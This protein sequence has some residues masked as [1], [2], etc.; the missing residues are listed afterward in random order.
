ML[1]LQQQI[2]NRTRTACYICNHNSISA[3]VITD[4]EV[5]VLVARVMGGRPTDSGATQY[6]YVGVTLYRVT[7]INFNN[8]VL[9]YL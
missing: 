8:F 7:A 4:T 5:V 9:L 6:S 3:E 1:L 2:L